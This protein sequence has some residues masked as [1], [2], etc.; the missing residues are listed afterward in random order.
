MGLDDQPD[1][2]RRVELH[3]ELV[4]L[5]VALERREPQPGRM[6]EHQPK[7]RLGHRQP[8]AGA[9]EERHSRPAPVLDLEPQRGVRLRRRARIDAVDRAVTVVLPAHV[10][11]GIGLLDRAEERDLRVLDRL[12]VAAR[13]RLHRTQR[14]DLHQVI[15]DDVAQRP[16]R[17]VEVAAVLDPEVLRHRD[18]HRRDVVSAP[19]RLEHRVR[20]PQMD[21]L[22]DAHLPQVVIDPEELRLVDRGVQLVGER[23]R[24]GA[25]V[26]ERLLDNDARTLGQPRVRE[27]L[28]DRAEQ[29]RRDL[30][31]EHG[32]A[33]VSDRL[34]DPLV[35]G[36]V[37]EVAG[38]IRQTRREAPEHL[39]VEL[40]ARSD[41]RLARALDETID[42]PV[43]ERHAEDRA[44]EQAPPLQPVQRTE[45]HHLR[46][47]ARD[48]EHHQ[49]VCMPAFEV[50]G[51]K[52]SGQ[53]LVRQRS[54]S[55]LSFRRS[56]T[57]RLMTTSPV[58]ST[59]EELEPEL[60]EALDVTVQLRLV[61]DPAGQHRRALDPLHLHAVE[62]VSETGI[63]LAPDDDPVRRPFPASSP[64][65]H[66][67]G[68]EVGERSVDGD[69]PRW[70][71]CR[72]RQPVSRVPAAFHPGEGLPSCSR[73]ALSRPTWLR[74]KRSH[75]PWTLIRR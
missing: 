11:R 37:A 3:D 9:D 55:P 20:E 1:P 33:R 59:V 32:Q 6:L 34:C 28:H 72:P 8:L 47:V 54:L 57:P 12:R 25:V 7:L 73:S 14:D 68:A 29:E 40:L 23:T 52:V 46:Q 63:E 27:P 42:R 70:T 60:L 74:L 75:T 67:P 61:D 10:V 26:A 49:P 56:A 21:D 35:G 45:G 64:S 41:D 51:L 30:E 13:R 22:L 18:L 2:R 44:V 31:I 19:D 17:I 69:S 65:R 38:H 43:V 66:E 48:P 15:D 39:L 4:R 50:R 5:D 58:C 53:W 71:A 24:R 16:D 36:R 62:E